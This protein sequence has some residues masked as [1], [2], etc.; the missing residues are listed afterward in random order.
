MQK[1]LPKRKNRAFHKKEE[2]WEPQSIENSS[3]HT[4]I[5]KTAKK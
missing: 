2:K 5:L 1:I 4:I 3:K